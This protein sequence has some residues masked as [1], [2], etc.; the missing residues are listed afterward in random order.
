MGAVKSELND[1]KNRNKAGCNIP[2]EL[3]V[4]LKELIKL[5]KDKTII[6]KKCDK[7][8]GIIILDNEEYIRATNAHLN[9]RITNEDKSTSPYY[10]KV[11]EPEILKVKTNLKNILLG[12]FDNRLIT[13]GELEAMDPEGKNVSKFYLTFKV[14]K[15]HVHGKAHM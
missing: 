10:T 2:K 11:D 6:I 13:K 1:P 4:A 3:I 8:A 12:A 9:S 14:H 7:G 5:Q 15:E